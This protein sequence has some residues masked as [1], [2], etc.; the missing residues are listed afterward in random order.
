ML[1]AWPLRRTVSFAVYERGKARYHLVATELERYLSGT[2]LDVGS[3]D[4]TLAVVSGKPCALL[5]KN[6]PA[7]PPFDWEHNCLPY[8][9]RSFDTV[10]CLDTLEHLNR[11]HEAFDDLLRVSRGNV[12]VSLPNCWRRAVIELVTAH[13]RE[14]SYGLPLEQPKDRH[15]WFFS[16][17]DALRFLVYRAL[18][19]PHGYEVACVRLHVPARRRWQRLIYPLLQ[20]ILPRHF[21]NLLVRTV[22]VVLARR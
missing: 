18:R 21:L 7:L 17:E 1:A 3:R 15:H 12:I 22:F 5:D 8:D 10:V 20:R 13:G 6:N 19:A 4:D 14:P 16:S 11:P 9:D 2:L